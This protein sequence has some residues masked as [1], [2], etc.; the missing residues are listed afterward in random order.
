MSN[1]PPVRI[2][3][4]EVVPGADLVVTDLSV[5]ALGGADIISGGDIAVSWTLG[6]EGNLVATGRHRRA[7]PGAQRQRHGACRPTGAARPPRCRSGRG[8]ASCTARERCG[9]PWGAAGAG[10]LT[11]RVITDIENAIDESL[12][13]G[14]AEGNNTTNTGFVALLAV[15]PDLTTSNVTA[16]PAGGWTPGS[17][18]S[19][20]WTT[21]NS[22]NQT[23]AR[24]WTERIVVR[25]TTTGAI[26]LT[27][28]VAISVAEA[29]GAQCV[30]RPHD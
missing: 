3:T 2:N 10:N 20:S 29:L 1:G 23:P 5:A 11:F 18:V 8:G 15:Y 19:V 4:L 9:C 14:N 30:G 22:G 27:R 26:L 24:G 12:P 28:D 7:H 6:N 16:S 17:T 13:I 25:N 21:T